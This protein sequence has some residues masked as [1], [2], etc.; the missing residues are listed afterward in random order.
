MSRSKKAASLAFV[1]AAT[2]ATFGLQV[3]SA[4]AAAGTWH[5]QAPKGTPYHGAFKAR[6]TATARH[7]YRIIVR[8][9]QQ[10]GAS[11]GRTYN[12]STPKSL[13]FSG[14]A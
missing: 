12:V 10:R 5:I 9:L 11:P 6:G 2:A 7:Y 1:G 13:F 14:P 4:L 3:G 8:L